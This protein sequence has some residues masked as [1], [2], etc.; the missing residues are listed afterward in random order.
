MTKVEFFKKLGNIEES[1]R[2]RIEEVEQDILTSIDYLK[3]IYARENARFKAGDIIIDH[4]PAYGPVPFTII[5]V[6]SLKTTIDGRRVYVVYKGRELHP[7][8][9]EAYSTSWNPRYETIFDDG[10]HLVEKIDK[11]LYTAFVD[12]TAEGKELPARDYRDSIEVARNELTSTDTEYVIR[13]GIKE[14]GTREEIQELTNI[15]KYFK[16]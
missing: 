8:F 6:E 3:D 5:R 11:P 9:T 2:R 1:R 7:D 16:K 13:Y 10:S 14:D 15:R 12:V 4:H